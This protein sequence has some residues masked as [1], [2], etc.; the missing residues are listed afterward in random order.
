MHLTE[1]AARACGITTQMRSSASTTRIGRVT[2]RS[3]MSSQSGSS[4][5]DLAVKEESIDG[6]SYR[7]NFDRIEKEFGLRTEYGVKDAVEE[8]YRAFADKTIKNLDEDVLPVKYR[9]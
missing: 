5:V 7:V 1:W 9:L 8:I 3:M 4:G 6:R 2:G